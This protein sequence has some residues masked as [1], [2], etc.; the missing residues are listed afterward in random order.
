MKKYCEIDSYIL[1]GTKNNPDLK[2][3]HCFPQIQ[4]GG[5]QKFLVLA[6]APE[7]LWLV[8]TSDYKQVLKKKRHCTLNEQV[9]LYKVTKSPSYHSSESSPCWQR[10]PWLW[11][12]LIS[13]GYQQINISFLLDRIFNWWACWCSS[14]LTWWHF[15]GRTSCFC[16]SWPG[17]AE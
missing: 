8:T 15:I 6:E 4:V 16:V 9:S 13:W 7:I 3:Y 12:L 11:E 1:D 17:W 10:L 5:I 14:Q 2:S